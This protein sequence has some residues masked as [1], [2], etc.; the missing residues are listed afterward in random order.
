MLRQVAYDTLSRR[1]RK[2]RHLT[3]AA[4]LRAAFPGDGEEVTDVIAR[5]Y[6]DALEA[7]PADPDTAEIRGQAI[8]RADPG[9]RAR[10]A[11]PAPPPG[12]RQL[13]RSRGPDLA[14]PPAQQE[15]GRRRR[16]VWERAATAAA[17][18]ADWARPSSRRAGRR[19]PPAGA[20]RPGPRPGPRPSLGRRC[21][22][23]AVML[24]RA[25]SSPPPSRFCGPIRHR[26]RPGPERTSPAGGVRWL[27]RR[28][29]RCRPR[30]W[31]LAR[32][33]VG[34]GDPDRLF[35]TCGIGLAFA[36]RRPEAAANWGGRVAGR[37]GRRQP[38]PGTAPWL[39]LADALTPTDP[40]VAA[41]AAQAAAAHARR[42]GDATAWRRGVQPGPGAADARRLGR[43]R[44]RAGP[45]R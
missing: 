23:G 36:S 37:P 8:A 32:P 26:H 34:G 3:V 29:P 38:A 18:S 11:A 43:R 1:D 25:S 16:R 7:V 40:A 2:A 31:P 28:G 12:R 24:R 4:H 10:R 41:E 13:R 44:G 15:A 9:R 17:T 20:G 33:C 39:N 5:H 14:G 30:R 35:S 45:G 42:A 22:I 19:L 6:L 27:A 21:A